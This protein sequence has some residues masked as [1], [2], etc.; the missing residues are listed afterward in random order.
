ME[1]QGFSGAGTRGTGSLTMSRRLLARLTCLILSGLAFG[2][3][4]DLSVSSYELIEGQTL[5]IRILMY[6]AE[7]ATSSVSFGAIPPSFSSQAAR[8]ESRFVERDGPG[9][10][11]RVP[12]THVSR[13]WV[14]SG[15]GNH[16]LGPFTLASRGEEITLPE[17]TVTVYQTPKGES[18]SLAWGTLEGPI[19]A[20]EA[21]RISLVASFEGTLDSVVCPAPEGAILETV[22][23]APG[24]S[25]VAEGGSLIV[26][27]YDWTPLS[28][29]KASLPEAHVAITSPSGVSARVYAERPIVRVENPRPETARLG[30]APRS[31]KDAKADETLRRAFSKPSPDAVVSG[32]RPPFPSIEGSERY[33]V[34]RE[35]ARLWDEGSEGK[36]LAALRS[37][38]YRSA[39]P[40]T[41]SLARRSA[42][43]ALSIER[44]PAVIPFIWKRIGVIAAV[45]CAILFAGVRL[46]HVFSRGR[47]GSLYALSLFFAISSVTL[48]ASGTFLYCLDARPMA[49]VISG[50]L[51]RVPESASS[52]LAVLKE[53]ESVVV[54]SR[55]GGWMFVRD[56]RGLEGWMRDEQVAAYSG[57]IREGGGR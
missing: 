40:F 9:T 12:G 16:T 57:G 3:E 6:P 8:K 52:P 21:R 13:E 28:P 54:L 7:P 11:E 10:F 25:P 19:H 23:T 29:G 38:E 55:A 18:R 15:E 47:K 17:I 33:P 22:F 35:A 27:E 43:N 5:T 42:E 45:A 26:A 32:A 34:I 4:A 46:V 37:A 41:I 20:K 24:G 53:G 31:R 36:A 48:A 1:E 49:V 50:G 56:R 39:F 51:M 44:A 30:A 14:V 2:F